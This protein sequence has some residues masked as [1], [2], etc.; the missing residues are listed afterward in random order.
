VITRKKNFKIFR[1]DFP[2]IDNKKRT[3]RENGN[4]PAKHEKDLPRQDGLWIRT[5]E[6]SKAWDRF[7]ETLRL[8][9]K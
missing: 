8:I 2:V 3:K 5:V 1:P 9:K 7:K 6:T 4:P